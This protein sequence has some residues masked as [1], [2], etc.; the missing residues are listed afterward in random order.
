M[1]VKNVDTKRKKRARKTA[2]PTKPMLEE[3]MRPFPPP[4]NLTKDERI[5][6]VTRMTTRMFQRGNPR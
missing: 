4:R 6:Y 2:V 1:N 3:D 5:A